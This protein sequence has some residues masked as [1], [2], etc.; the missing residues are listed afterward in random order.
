MKDDDKRSTLNSLNSFPR[1]AWECRLDRS[2]V[3]RGPRSA[4]ERRRRHSHAERGNEFDACANTN[5][6]PT[7][8]RSSTAGSGA[9]F[10][11]DGGGNERR[12]DT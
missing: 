3:P 7:A 12:Q 2:A 5:I 1:S 8:E 10:E 6:G 9:T 11:T 4:A